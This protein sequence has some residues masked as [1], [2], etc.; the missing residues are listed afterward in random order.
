MPDSSNVATVIGNKVEISL[1]NFAGVSYARYEKGSLTQGQMK[2]KGTVLREKNGVYT[3]DNV[4]NGW[5]TI[6]IQTDKRDYFNIS[7][8]VSN[9]GGK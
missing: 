5:Y 6:Y 2:T 1:K 9:K 4:S 3:I 8:Y 7:V